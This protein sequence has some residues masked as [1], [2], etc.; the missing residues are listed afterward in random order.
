MF[1]ETFLVKGIKIKSMQ[2]YPNDT[3]VEKN[4]QILFLS[5]P[6][7]ATSTPLRVSFYIYTNLEIMIGS[8]KK[9]TKKTQD[10][11]QAKSNKK[12][13]LVKKL[14]KQFFLYK[15]TETT[16]STTYYIE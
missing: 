3:N 12:N 9:E 14:F 13:L 2:G 4:E 1:K 7:A 6:V 8:V 11:S 15:K 16:I 5:I 10:L